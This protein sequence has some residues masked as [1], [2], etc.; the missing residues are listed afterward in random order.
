VRLGWRGL[1]FAVELVV[2]AA[3]FAVSWPEATEAVDVRRYHLLPGL[4]AL[5]ALIAFEAAVLWTLA[6]LVDLSRAWAK[7]VVGVTFLWVFVAA[8]GAVALV[9]RL[10]AG[11]PT[12]FTGTLDHF[13]SG[14]NN[15]RFG[16]L[17]SADG[18]R[19]DVP[20]VALE[21]HHLGLGASVTVRLRPG[22]VFDAGWIVDSSEPNAT[23]R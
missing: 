6:P 11:A 4:L 18:Q 17:V 5:V 8:V 20:R 15:T 23:E 12:H 2:L 19:L 16:Q 14:R 22:L 21:R 3:V 7:A 1:A 9:N 13:G 10:D